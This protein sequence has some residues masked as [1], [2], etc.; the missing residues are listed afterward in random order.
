MET[1]TNNTG[2]PSTTVENKKALLEQSLKILTTVNTG[3]IW[4]NLLS[5][6]LGI[7]IDDAE[8]IINALVA[9]GLIYDKE[10]RAQHVPE[11][12]LRS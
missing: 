8:D 3:N 9:S 7:S 4:G 6:R 10:H 12:Y 11:W 5:A 2:E 1:Q